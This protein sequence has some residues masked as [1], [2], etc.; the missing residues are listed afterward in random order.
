[1]PKLFPFHQFLTRLLNILPLLSTNMPKPLHPIL[2]MVHFLFLYHSQNIYRVQ[3]F[4]LLKLRYQ[5]LYCVHTF[6]LMEEGNA[7]DSL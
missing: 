2:K 7:G 3:V 6:T 4:L 1:M 5:F